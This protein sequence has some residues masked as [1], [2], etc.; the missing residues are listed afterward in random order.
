[1]GLITPH[2]THLTITKT[3]KGRPR[4]DPGCSAAADDDDIMVC[5]SQLIITAELQIGKR[6]PLLDFGGKTFWSNSCNTIV[7]QD[8]SLGTTGLD[9]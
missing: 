7:L 8:H 9:H 6:L 3:R 2:H 1:M 5:S 4:P